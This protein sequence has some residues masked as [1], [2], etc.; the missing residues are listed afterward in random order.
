MSYGFRSVNPVVVRRFLDP[1]D[2]G[3]PEQ[4]KH[5][6]NLWQWANDN[7]HLPGEFVRVFEQARKDHK[8][9]AEIKNRKP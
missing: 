4:D 3:T 7:I 1:L 6:D 5:A 2:A 8:A 9:A